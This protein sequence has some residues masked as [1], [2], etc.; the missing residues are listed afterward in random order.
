M[1]ASKD[2]RSPWGVRVYFDTPEFAGMMDEALFLAGSQAFRD[3]R[4]VDVDLVI[5]KAYGL[6]PDYVNLR[7]GVLGRTL[8]QKDGSASIE[9]S[10][11]LAD[12]AETDQLARRRLRTTLAHEAGH[13]AC[14]R[15]LFVSDTE[16]LPLFNDER[17]E[18]EEE[19]PAILCRESSVAI[20][21]YQGEWWEFQAN[22]CMAC[23]LLPR[24]LVGQKV[25]EIFAHLGVSDF[26]EAQAQTLDEEVIRLVSDSFDV[27][28][29]AVTY[30]LQ[31]LGFVP[32]LEHASQE[33]IAF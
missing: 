29:Q 4:G 20:A 28:W 30:R 27:S 31:E 10:R 7:D 33:T 1:R 11:A 2:S 21:G 6:E 24:R 9:I 13:A 25:S 16:T 26:S 19:K 3:G 15:Q 12:L 32:K 23:L 8:F 17:M 22:Q 5:L 18:N 14:H